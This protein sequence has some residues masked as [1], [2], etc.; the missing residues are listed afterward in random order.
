MSHVFVWKYPIELS[1]I[2]FASLS[3]VFETIKKGKI[4][5]K[6]NKI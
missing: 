2:I 6:L 1:L 3:A 4:D 5:K